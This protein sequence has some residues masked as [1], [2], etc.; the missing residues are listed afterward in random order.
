MPTRHK[1]NKR[2]EAYIKSKKPPKRRMKD[3]RD[4]DVF[5]RRKFIKNVVEEDNSKD[6]TPSAS[7]EEEEETG[8]GQMMQIFGGNVMDNH[9]IESDSSDDGDDEEQNEDND[10]AGDGE[11]EV[12]DEGG[13]EIGRGKCNERPKSEERS[14]RKGDGQGGRV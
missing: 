14:R 7:E 4:K 12:K 8:F 1:H 3:E 5:K 6:E 10:D 9:A 13:R 2:K 11:G